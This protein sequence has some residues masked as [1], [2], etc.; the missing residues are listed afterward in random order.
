MSEDQPRTV[1]EHGIP[2]E[3]ISAQEQLDRWVAGSPVHRVDENGLGE[4]CPDFSCCRPSLLSPPQERQ[5]F[6][7]AGPAGR[8]RMLTGFL[9]RHV[10]SENVHVVGATSGLPG[11][12]PVNAPWFD[13]KGCGPSDLMLQLQDLSPL[14][15]LSPGPNAGRSL[16]IRIRANDHNQAPILH[17][18]LAGAMVDSGFMLQTEQVDALH[19]EL[20]AWLAAGRPSVES[21]AMDEIVETF[22]QGNLALSELP[23]ET[24][25]SIANAV[26][27]ETVRGAALRAL[28]KLRSTERAAISDVG[29][30][31]AAHHAA[32]MVVDEMSNPTSAKG[33]AVLRRADH[34]VTLRVK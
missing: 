20:G 3:A 21:E 26:L 24:R 31:R 30:E 29:I 14:A 10:Q 32:T 34:L 5:A 19:A 1:D 2:S 23:V 4:C 28:T 27:Y 13:A 18:P 15:A 33:M 16:G 12:E 11:S 7:D 8:E 9:G 6:R 17:S 25:R 22:L